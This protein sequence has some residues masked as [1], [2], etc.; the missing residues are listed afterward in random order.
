VN[1]LNWVRGPQIAVD[2][3]RSVFSYQAAMVS[4]AARLGLALA[5][6]LPMDMKGHAAILFA[7]FLLQLHTLNL[8]PVGHD[9]SDQMMLVVTPALA[10]AYAFRLNGPCAWV[11][12]WCN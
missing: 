5:L 6:I 2:L 7:I 4:Q 8:S 9:G 10:V 12:I 11:A 3:C 1:V